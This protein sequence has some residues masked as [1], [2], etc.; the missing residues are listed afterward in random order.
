MSIRLSDLWGGIFF[1]LLSVLFWLQLNNAAFED[2][3]I[4]N[5]PVWYPQILLICSGL[6]SIILILRS[7]TGK[8][9]KLPKPNY[10]KC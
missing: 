8:K 6:A 5:N 2:V 4:A 7:F 3:E 1:L 10:L 9:E